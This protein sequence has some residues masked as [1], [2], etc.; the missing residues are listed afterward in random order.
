MDRTELCEALALGVVNRSTDVVTQPGGKS[1]IVARTLRRLGQEVSV[2]GFLG[3]SVGAYVR[4]G[5]TA[6]GIVDRHTSIRGETRITTVL[7]TPSANGATVVNEPG[8]VVEADESD[9]LLRTLGAECR[10]GDIVVLTGSL[11]RG[12]SE[13]YYAELVETVQS[14]GA[15]AVLDTSG[16]PLRLAA[17]RAPWMIKPNLSE[18][19]AVTG[20]KLPEGNVEALVAGMHALLDRGIVLVV[21]TLGAAGLVLGSEHITLRVVPPKLVEVN[22]TGSGDAFLAGFITGCA[23]G[24]DLESALRLGTAAGAVN[25]MTF[26]ADLDTTIDL[27]AIGRSVE[28]EPIRGGRGPLPPRR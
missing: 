20:Y 10:P 19:A 22:A 16:T 21:V 6:V 9:E 2:Y 28:I 8:P 23:R 27:A 3:G 7:V 12:V 17:E 25:A 15:L 14:A 13:R 5:C 4:D 24:D 1:L 26:E 11:P 18:F